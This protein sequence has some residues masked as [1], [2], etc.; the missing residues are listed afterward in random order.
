MKS[1]YDL[2]V[3]HYILSLTNVVGKIIKTEKKGLI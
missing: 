1:D 2:A 3:Q